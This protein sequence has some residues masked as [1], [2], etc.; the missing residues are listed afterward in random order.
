MALFKEVKKPVIKAAAAGAEISPLRPRFA[1][2][3]AP[4]AAHCPNHSQVRE[5]LML[6]A[7]HEAYQRTRAQAFELAWRQ[8]TEVNPFPASEA[9]VCQHAC[10]QSCNRKAK[11]GAVAIHLI[12]RFLGD[13]ALAHGFKLARTN[14]VALG[15]I[16]VVGAGPAG[17]SCAYQVARRG[18]PVTVFDAAPEPGGMMRYGVPR[19]VIP[20]AVLDAEIANVLAFGVQL[21]CNCAV[22]RDVALTDIRRDYAVVFLANGLQKPA[23]LTLTGDG[24]GAFVAGELPPEP[25]TGPFLEAEEFDPRVGNAVCPSV[26]QGRQMAESIDALLCGR[27]ADAKAA[28]PVI[29]AEQMKLDWYTAAP[30]HADVSPALIPGISEE[31]VIAEAKRCMSCGMC[32]DCETCWMYCSSNCFV[33]LPKGEHYRI[34]L[35]L[36]DGCKKC[37]DA[38]PCGYI[39]LN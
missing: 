7:Q 39:E 3:T 25:P 29:K 15:P 12:E 8:V 5:W 10:E 11:E 14:G 38:C 31:E 19:S 36:C 28:P 2:K 32:M 37:A 4:C 24:E 34:K 27:A 6:I 20:G 35:E 26:A 30:P 21:R 22:G 23:R 1:E 13:Y 17:L 9:R 18:Y 33:K 16:A